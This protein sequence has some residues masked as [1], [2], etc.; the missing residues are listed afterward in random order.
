MPAL[1]CRCL[2]ALAEALKIN[3][4]ITDF[5]LYDN[6]IG[7]EGAKALA[8]T[9]KIN[10]SVTNIDLS[11]R[12][13]GDEGAKALAEALQINKSITNIDLQYNQI[14]AEGAKALAE[15]L[16]INGSV[17]NIDLQY[18]QIGAEGAKEERDRQARRTPFETPVRL[19]A[20]AEA[21]KI[22]TSLTC[23]GS[24]DKHVGD[25]GAKVCRM[26]IAGS[27]CAAQAAAGELSTAFAPLASAIWAAV[28]SSCW[29]GVLRADRMGVF[30]T[31]HVERDPR[32]KCR[33]PPL[34]RF[35]ARFR[36]LISNHIAVCVAD[37]V[38]S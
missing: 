18:N 23:I 14:G 34:C 21:L 32:E 3:K 38:A 16:K 4:C 37:A 9:L 5:I 22:N 17:T 8:E 30:L 13:I 31:S 20:L 33:W 19:Q 29:P 6:D 36:K 27:L 2:Q 1:I 28:E 12:Q 26:G 7:A 24:F 11:V 25:E 15:A 10:A 35:A